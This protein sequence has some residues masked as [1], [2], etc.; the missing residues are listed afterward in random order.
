MTFAVPVKLVALY[1]TKTSSGAAEWFHLH[2]CNLLLY[3]TW[4]TGT[5]NPYQDNKVSTES[6][7]K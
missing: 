1:A 3:L 5:P 4:Y 7:K 2:N 6:V